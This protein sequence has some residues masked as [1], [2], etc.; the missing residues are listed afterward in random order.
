[1][2]KADFV[3]LKTKQ[4]IRNVPVPCDFET[5]Q[6]LFREQFGD[7]PRDEWEVE[8]LVL[9]TPF[10]VYEGSIFLR[11]SSFNDVVRRFERFLST[12]GWR[13]TIAFLEKGSL[14]L[15]NAYYIEGGYSLW[16]FNSPEEAFAF[17]EEKGF[18]DTDTFKKSAWLGGEDFYIAK[19]GVVVLDDCAL[20]KMEEF[21]N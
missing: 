20:A 13:K 9:R 6:S 12:Y 8:C 14:G 2:L 3:N 21:Y 11:F 4:R 7:F 10:G 16:F 18:K 5:V 1:M 19:N 15:L 17:L